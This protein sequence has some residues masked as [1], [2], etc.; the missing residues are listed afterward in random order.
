MD[1]QELNK[2]LSEWRWGTHYE[3]YP[4]ELPYQSDYPTFTHSLDAC[5]KWLVPKL[6]TVSLRVGRLATDA[7]VEYEGIE[8]WHTG[9]ETPALALCLAIEKLIGEGD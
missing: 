3:W 2:K 5:F 6:N 7:F 9:K 8:G 1:E 4:P